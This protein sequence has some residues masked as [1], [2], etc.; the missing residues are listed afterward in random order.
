MA[1]E[2]IEE[3]PT[4][5][6]AISQETSKWELDI[7]EVISEVERVFGGY[8]YWI[9]EKGN[10]K[11]TK[12]EDLAVVNEKGL[13]Y[14]KSKI[15]L[16]IH[17]GTA[18]SELSED[19]I[20][21]FVLFKTDAVRMEMRAKRKEFGIKKHFFESMILDLSFLLYSWLMRAHKGGERIYRR[22]I[23]RRVIEYGERRKGLMETF[24]GIFRR[25]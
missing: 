11:V 13:N 20:K 17:Q 16:I 18:L 6:M 4:T 9:D 19:M 10:I 7:K 25:S 1:V 14:L 23:E 8:E 21:K 2:S 5:T 22:G 24:S 3:S 12:H 15:I